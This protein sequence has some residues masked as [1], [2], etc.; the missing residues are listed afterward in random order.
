MTLLVTPEQ[1]AQLDLGQ[2]LGQLAL[3]LRNLSDTTIRQTTPALL[4]DITGQKDSGKSVIGSDRAVVVARAPAAPPKEKEPKPRGEPKGKT[5]SIFLYHIM[6]IRG[7]QEDHL[8]IPVGI[9]R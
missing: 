9:E 6:A 1:A 5:R 4:S 3:S 2:N 7:T 8:R